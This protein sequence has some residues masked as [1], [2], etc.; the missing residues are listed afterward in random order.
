MEPGRLFF[1]NKVVDEHG[2]NKEPAYRGYRPEILDPIVVAHQIT[3]AWSASGIPEQIGMQVLAE[4]CLRKFVSLAQM[5]VGRSRTASA[6]TGKEGDG[7]QLRHLLPLVRA[8][9]I[10]RILRSRPDL[11]WRP[12]ETSQSA[13]SPRL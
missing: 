5:E 13:K 1:R 2:V 10:E 8:E 12:D 4:E 3:R 7:A 11:K 6:D 9:R